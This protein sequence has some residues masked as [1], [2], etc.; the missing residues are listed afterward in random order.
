M[1]RLLLALAAGVALGAAVWSGFGGGTRPPAPAPVPEDEAL[2]EARQVAAILSLAAVCAHGGCEDT[3]FG[4][5]VAEEALHQ[6]TEPDPAF[7][8]DC[9]GYVSAVFTALGVPMDGVVI[10]LWDLAVIHDALHWEEPPRLGDL[11]FFEKTYD[12]DL[13]ELT[14]VGVVVDLLEDGTVI[15]AHAGTSTGRKLGRLNVQHPA[16]HQWDGVE[17]NSFLRNPHRGDAPGQRYLA[18][19]LWMAFATV[20]PRLDWLSVPP[21]P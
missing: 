12:R 8:D 1:R 9:S 11:V 17:V 10:S 4:T 20:D 14:H 13:D 15:F 3:R 6:L 16:E 18:G 7:R 2:R 5:E 21:P 19:E